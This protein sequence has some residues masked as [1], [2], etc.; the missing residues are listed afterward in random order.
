M[1]LLSQ[2][3]RRAVLLVP[4]LA[5]LLGTSIAW[6]QNQTF[7]SWK[8][9]TNDGKLL[10]VDILEGQVIVDNKGDEGREPPRDFVDI[11]YLPTGLDLLAIDGDELFLYPGGAYPEPPPIG[12]LDTREAPIPILTALKLGLRSLVTIEVDAVTGQALVIGQAK[13][14]PVFHAYLCTDVSEPDPED[15]CLLVAKEFPRPIA[16]NYV[17]V[18]AT[19]DLDGGGGFLLTGGKEVVV[20]LFDNDYRPQTIITKKGVLAGNEQI[21]DLAWFTEDIVLLGTSDRRL[22]KV[23]LSGT[24]TVFGSP[25][26]T[27]ADPCT[28]DRDQIIS[29]EVIEDDGQT[30]VLSADF[31]CSV[32]TL[33]DGTTEDDL[34]TLQLRVEPEPGVFVDLMPEGVTVTDGEFLDLS[35][36]LEGCPFAPEDAATVTLKSVEGPT[37]AVVY[38]AVDMVDCRCDDSCM[39]K[40]IILGVN[41]ALNWIDILPEEVVNLGIVQDPTWISS[42]TQGDPIGNCEVGAF[43]VATDPDTKTGIIEGFW[44]VDELLEPLPKR[45]CVTGSLRSDE[46]VIDVILA[47]D[48]INYAPTRGET[49]CPDCDPD[50]IPSET[51][52]ETMLASNACGS[53]GF[54]GRGFS[55][56]GYGFSIPSGGDPTILVNVT[57]QLIT[58]LGTAIDELAQP[59]LSSLSQ[60]MTLKHRYDLVYSKWTTAKAK[61]DD[62]PNAADTALGALIAQLTN[63]RKE[64]QDAEYQSDLDNIQGEVEVRV[65]VAIFVIDERL[66]PSVPLDGF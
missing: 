20:M 34:G 62:Q 60:Y 51:G 45:L 56:I 65:D 28:S 6:G 48:V 66:R 14:K 41:R 33:Y 61:F 49:V 27:G 53:S 38:H 37:G 17:P 39:G 15:R 57:D 8:L 35:G 40:G 18:D 44:E 59:L 32:A 42:M 23:Q 3:C 26:G 2:L 10:L 31:A 43:I 58:D 11:A 36:C 22:L 7:Q 24:T 30:Y 25:P 19:G 5:M 13:G 21:T 1:K 64:N 46:P 47:W 29:V 52:F 12:E 63:L 54:K 55:I 16:S 9:H 50:L 4:V